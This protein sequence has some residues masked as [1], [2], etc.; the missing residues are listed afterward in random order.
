MR[1]R[2]ATDRPTLADVAAQ[3]GVSSITVSRFFNEPARVGEQAR[4]RIQ[5]AVEALNY[6]PNLAAGGLASAHNKVVAMVVPNISGPIFAHTLQ[7]LSDGLS[8]AGYQLLLASSYFSLEAEERAV[9]AFFG[10]QPAALVLT[11]RHHSTGTERLIEAAGMPVI[12]TWDLAQRRQPY[13][14]GFSHRQVGRDGVGYLTARGY[15]RIA[16]VHNSAAGDLSAQERCEGYIEALKERGL[17]PILYTPAAEIGPLEA[18][19]QALEALMNRSRARPQA[20]FFANDNL[21]CGAVLAAQRR[22]LTVPGDVALFGFGDYAF[23][24]KLLPSLS[25]IRPPAREIGECAAQHILALAE[26]R[27][28]PRQV[29]LPCE[30]MSR[31]SA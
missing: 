12:E 24:D 18:G 28:P 21:A 16:F 4:A 26:G 11:S 7:S 17:E 31:E 9:R 8:S 29:S 2:R 25:T 1:K 15:K 3:A 30:L 20:I 10:W 23:A 22:R 6:V 5:A 14:I 19:A 27:T 13:Q